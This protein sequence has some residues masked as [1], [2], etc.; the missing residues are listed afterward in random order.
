MQRT[1]PRQVQFEDVIQALSMDSLTKFRSTT[2]C[3]VLQAIRKRE[4]GESTRLNFRR[5]LY[6]SVVPNHTFEQVRNI[7]N[8]IP[9]RFTICGKYLVTISQNHHDL[10]L[11]RLEGGDIRANW[12]KSMATAMRNELESCSFSRYFTAHYTVPIA[13]NRETLISDFCLASSNGRFLILAAFTR[14]PD[15][16]QAEVHANLDPAH[17]V[18]GQGDD[19]NLPNQLPA[20]RSCPVLDRFTLYLVEVESG[21]VYDRFTMEN[22]FVQLEGNRGI[23][24]YQNLLCI[25]SLRKQTL[26]VLRIQENL[27]RF[28]LDRSIGS[29]CNAD[30][31]YEIERVY[32]NNNNNHEDANVTGDIECGLGNGKR[33]NAQY[34]G[35]MQ[36]LLAYVYKEFAR[37]GN[38]A[39]FY[40]YISQ[41][42]MLLMLRVQLLSNDYVLIELG[43]EEDAGRVGSGGWDHFYLVYC[44]SK[45]TIIRLFHYRSLSLLH[46]FQNYHDM[47]FDSSDVAH[48]AWKPPRLNE[49]AAS[50][51]SEL[52]RR[53]QRTLIHLPARSVSNSPSPY[54]DRRLFAYDISRVSVPTRQNNAH[55]FIKFTSV[56]TGLVRFRLGFRTP[57]PASNVRLILHPILPFALSVA[58]GHVNF[59]TVMPDSNR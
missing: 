55:S 7:P 11:Y 53:A 12:P 8:V 26:H 37:K 42:S 21:R 31:N 14:G 22:D 25:L 49:F 58:V 2:K 51:R 52:A 44:L 28:I 32:G 16:D 40:Q 35:I 3:S 5:K 18:Q 48:T 43:P 15:N 39:K 4:L 9:I 6:N 24:I 27:G 1:R 33:R 19:Q 59:H 34:C 13:N 54:L 10:A 30:D 50:S 23:H 45:S 41:Y 46:I 36:K 57:V 20:V 29:I 56:H 47:F 38:V 17:G